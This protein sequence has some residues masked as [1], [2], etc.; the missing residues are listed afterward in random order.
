MNVIMLKK[1]SNLNV[2]N[3]NV[4]NKINS[5]TFPLEFIYDQK[6][7]YEFLFLWL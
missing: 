3:V 1:I 7:C 2:K 4:F 6:I 5:Y